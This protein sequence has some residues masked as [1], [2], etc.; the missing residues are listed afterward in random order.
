M[1]VVRPGLIVGPG[2]NSDRFTYWPARADRGGEILA[3]GSASD[4]TQFIDVRDL[5][6]FLLHAIEQRSIGT[7]NADA[8]AGKLTMGALLSACQRAAG[9]PSTLAWVPADFLEAHGV[10]AWQDMPAWLPATGENAGFGRV[11]TARA[12]AI[13]LKYRP[14]DATVADTLA[15]WRGLPEARRAKPAAGITP[16][17]EAEVLKAWHQHEA[18]RAG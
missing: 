16:A 5:A 12:Q 18:E 9:K 11:S 6:G 14:L 1:I 3:P 17:R 13:G 15:W 10:S 7:Y 4:P 2:D 8:P